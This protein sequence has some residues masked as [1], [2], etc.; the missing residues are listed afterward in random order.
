MATQ[1][2]AAMTMTNRVTDCASRPIEPVKASEPVITVSDQR[3]SAG[4]H[5]R[6]SRRSS[7][8]RKCHTFGRSKAKIER[9]LLAQWEL[10]MEVDKGEMG[11]AETDGALSQ[12]S[13]PE[14]E[15]HQKLSNPY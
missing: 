3:K 13:A 8:A 14:R 2:Q 1:F 9:L 12:I 7:Y 6:Q 4:S 11:Q 10:C 15:P 5:Q